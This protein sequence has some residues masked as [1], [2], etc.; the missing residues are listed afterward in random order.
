MPITRRL[1]SSPNF[2]L[3][4]WYALYLGDLSGLLLIIHNSIV[5]YFLVSHES[6]KPAKI[7]NNKKR[8][9]SMNCPRFRHMIT[10]CLIEVESQRNGKNAQQGI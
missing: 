6:G 1:P 10:H 8:Y 7:N 2:F 3:N 4:S 5:P 9:L